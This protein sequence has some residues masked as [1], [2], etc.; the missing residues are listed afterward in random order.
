MKE[1]QELAAKLLADGAVQVVL[2]YEEGPRGVRPAFITDPR[3]P[4]GWSS[5]RV[6][7]R[8]WLRI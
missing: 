4:D 5:M 7:C 6:A 2:G 3:R 1:L 8:T